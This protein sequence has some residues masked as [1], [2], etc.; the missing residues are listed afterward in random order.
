[1][2]ASQSGVAPEGRL[3]P[4]GCVRDRISHEHCAAKGSRTYQIVVVQVGR[5]R[6]GGRLGEAESP[7][8]VTRLTAGLAHEAVASEAIQS[9]VRGKHVS[10]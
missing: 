6:L 8:R 5:I 10:L 4:S 9:P 1:M 2:Q 7:G 3:V